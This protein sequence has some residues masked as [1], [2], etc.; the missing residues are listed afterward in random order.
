MEG[1]NKGKNPAGAKAKP[2]PKG[3]GKGAGA[4]SSNAAP[5]LDFDVD[6]V[7]EH[8]GQEDEVYSEQ[9][10]SYTEQKYPVNKKP[11][12]AVPETSKKSKKKKK[13]SKADTQVSTK[14][15]DKKSLDSI[16]E[17]LS[18][19]KKP[20]QQRVNQNERASGKDIE[21]NEA[22]P[23][24]S[25]ILSIDPKHLKAENEMRRIFGSKVVD[26]LENQRNVPSSSRPLRGVR[27]A[28]HN[29]RKTLLVTP[30]SYWPP[31]DKS[32]SMDLLETKSGFN[33]FR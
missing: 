18:I 22:T 3:G 29:P 14:L 8:A 33:Y 31:W 26:S 11:S 23:E 10:V 32:M 28:T 17:D 4:A 5:S 13:K 19:E 1:G 24:T 30:S 25:S 9:P 15:R 12:N 27:R 21:I 16:L 6:W 20:T 2:K 7:A